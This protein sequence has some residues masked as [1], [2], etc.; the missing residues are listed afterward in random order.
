MKGYVIIE[1]F[2]INC[3]HAFF[4]QEN[5]IAIVIN[6]HDIELRLFLSW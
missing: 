6:D 5:N 1:V 2:G 4:E 3:K